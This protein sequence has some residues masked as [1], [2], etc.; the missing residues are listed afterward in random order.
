[1]INIYKFQ[2]EKIYALLNATKNKSFLP[3]KSF[4]F[5]YFGLLCSISQE[6]QEKEKQEK[7]KQEKAMIVKQV[8]CKSLYRLP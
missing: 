4:C 1:M 7:E 5:T 6:E 3:F 8:Q 2:G